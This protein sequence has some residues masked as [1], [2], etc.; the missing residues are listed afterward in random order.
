MGRKH[1]SDSTLATCSG[2]PVQT[3][4]VRS[5]DQ[6]RD[7]KRRDPTRRSRG[8]GG[9]PPRRG[10]LRVALACHV[11]KDCGSCPSWTRASEVVSP[12]RNVVHITMS[13]DDCGSATGTEHG[14]QEVAAGAVGLGRRLPAWMGAGSE[15]AGAGQLAKGPASQRK[16]TLRPADATQAPAPSQGR[17]LP[18]L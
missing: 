1:R 5:P 8:P 17:P 15:R 13:K 16:K 7:S 18:L 10:G 9:R 6:S 4:A 14:K 2:R 11:L 12:E 3:R